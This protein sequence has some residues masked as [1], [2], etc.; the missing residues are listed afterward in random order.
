MQKIKSNLNLKRKSKTI[1]TKFKHKVIK[2]L[3]FRRLFKQFFIYQKKKDFFIKTNS[4][5]NTKR[6]MKHQFKFLF[7]FSYKSLSSYTK[8]KN[9][10]CIHFFDY[11]FILERSISI[12][13]IRIKFFIKY[14]FIKE[15]LKLKF[16]A[17]NGNIIN[18]LNYLLSPSDLLQKCK[19]KKYN[20]IIR[21]KL[22]YWRKTR[23]K[24]VSYI[25][26]KFYSKR[27]I[28]YYRASKISIFL[29][30]LE[31]NYKAN[32]AILLRNPIYQEVFS[33]F[34]PKSY[35]AFHHKFLY[36]CT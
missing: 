30:Y 2:S 31:I 26:K 24:K 25:I 28:N 3:R 16:I 23:W 13:L 14:N 11:W 10:S 35:T 21:C 18:R 4:L 12:L 17:V 27:Y 9:S 29:N 34:N 32:S 36:Y 19:L 20:S 22:Y 8:F 33:N 1:F 6:I 5:F 15:S 7:N